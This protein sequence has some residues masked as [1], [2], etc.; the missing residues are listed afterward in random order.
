MRSSFHQAPSRTV[1]RRSTEIHFKSNNAVSEDHRQG[2]EDHFHPLSKPITPKKA[3]IC[4][5]ESH[6]Q[7]KIQCNWE[8]FSGQE[9]LGFFFVEVVLEAIGSDKNTE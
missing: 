5:S 3:G 2:R 9:I 1:H 8:T 4:S 7:M 6:F